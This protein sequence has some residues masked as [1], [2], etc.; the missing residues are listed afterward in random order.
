MSTGAVVNLN[1]ATV[2]TP[3]GNGIN[4]QFIGGSNVSIPC[5]D[6]ESLMHNISKLYDKRNIACLY[7]DIK[8][9]PEASQQ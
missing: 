6:T 3:N 5:S 7:V 2:I 8:M 9:E 4:I 1:N